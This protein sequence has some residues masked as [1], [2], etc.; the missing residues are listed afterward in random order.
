MHVRQTHERFGR[1]GHSISMQA[2]CEVTG[3]DRRKEPALA[4]DALRSN[5]GIPIPTLALPSIPGKGTRHQT[6]GSNSYV[7]GIF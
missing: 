2:E 6:L 5:V 3:P 1:S 4:D 7:K